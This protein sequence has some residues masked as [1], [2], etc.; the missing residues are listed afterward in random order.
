MWTLVLQAPVGVLANITAFDSTSS[1][2]PPSVCL[3]KL[4]K[5]SAGKVLLGVRAAFGN[6]TMFATH[7][8]KKMLRC[9]PG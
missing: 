8:E 3:M 5:N 2:L 4:E 9:A 1:L 6:L 7:V